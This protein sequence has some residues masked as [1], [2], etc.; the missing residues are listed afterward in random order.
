MTMSIK[1]Y[2]ASLPHD[3]VENFLA[4]CTDAELLDMDRGAWWYTSRPEQIA[5][6]GDW[7]LW[8]IL[9]GRGFGKAVALGTPIPTPSGWTKIADIRVGDQVFDESGKPCTV[10]ATFD[11]VPDVA[12][13]LRFSDGTHVDACDEHE[14]VTWTHRDRKRYLRA[15]N[16]QKFPEDWAARESLTT[17]QIVDTL[18]FGKREDRNHCIP[19][20]APLCLPDADLP[21]D[22]YLLGVWLGDGHTRDS[23]VTSKDPEIVEAFTDAGYRANRYSAMTFGI[24]GG[25]RTALREARVLGAKHVPS[26][27]LRSSAAQRQALLQGLMDTDGHAHARS[28]HVEFCN[29]SKNLVDAVVELARSLGQKPV[30]AE[31]R[32][33]L[34]GRDCGAKWR[35]TWRPTIEVF[36][37]ARKLK[38]QAKEGG[39]QGLRNHHRMIIGAERIESSPMRC[40]TVDSP[41]SMFLV[42]EGMIPTHN[43][44]CVY[45]WLVE[46]VIKY[47][48]DTSGMPT[49]HL[50][51]APSIADCEN[52]SAEGESGILPILR[53]EGYRDGVD[54]SYVKSPRPK[55]VMR[56]HGT[57][58]FF[59]GADKSDAGRGLNLATIVL[60]EIIK[61]P[62]PRDLWLQALLPALRTNIPGDRP[63]AACATTPKPITL[64][65]EWAKEARGELPEEEQ[66][67]S[68]GIK[69]TRGSTYDNAAN[70]SEHAL[71]GFRR[72]YAGTSMGRQ[73]LEGELLDALDGPLFSYS[74]IDNNRVLAL[75]DII[76]HTSIGVDPNLTGAEDSDMMGCV[77][78]ARDNKEHMYVISDESKPL[79]S[80]DA[81]RH[82]WRTYA[83]YDADSVIVENNLGKA[84]L[85]KVL[86]DTYYQMAKEGFFEAHTHP[87]IVE[88]HAQQGKKTRAEPVALRYE[89]GRVHHMGV[90]EKLEEEMVGW[91][92]IS[93]KVSPDRMDA[94]V[95]ACTH[96]M[97]GERH[98]V[99]IINPLKHRLPALSMR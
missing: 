28:G 21:V 41:N 96:L 33:M 50:V 14:W 70:L 4:E 7:G 36:R 22:P 87:P 42:G 30:V 85:R 78:V 49:S 9:A 62:T 44:R 20:T 86:V 91:D 98:T 39:S 27:Y 8:L 25:F 10:T 57:K 24:S 80:G 67:K 13:R 60:D 23:A 79:T 11:R 84:W 56:E 54:F 53:R 19:V 75:P 46:R 66:R 82:I 74:D 45:E 69:V 34:N 40:L 90:F 48:V 64:L 51:V 5:P 61:F 15:E 17:A 65:K 29:T 1:E 97:A 6:E 94:M 63:R 18:T 89:Q 76:E 37:L 68:I 31:S 12:Y 55:I 59:V 38:G 73:E 47:P 77:V 72:A 26:A 16:G 81:A 95:W 58:I 2:L 93:A 32:A 35:V 43:S 52:I 83:K 88:V 99:K 92:P 3:Q 71:N